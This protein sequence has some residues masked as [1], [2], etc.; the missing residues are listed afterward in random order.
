MSATS[1]QAKQPNQAGAYPDFCSMKRLKEF[2][3]PPPPTPPSPLDGM[4]LHHRVT[5]S[6]N[7]AGTH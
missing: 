4:V 1:L 3:H 6:I 5:P 2:R 7:F